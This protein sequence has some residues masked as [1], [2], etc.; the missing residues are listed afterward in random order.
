MI[1]I[2]LQDK[3]RRGADN[4]IQRRQLLA[5]A[6]ICLLLAADY[7][8]RRKVVIREILQRQAFWVRSLILVCAICG[9]L[10]FGKWGPAIETA[11][12]IYFQF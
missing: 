9:I 12:F 11:S 3:V 5:M 8:K 2:L 10:V 4:G 6:C 1:L 7:L